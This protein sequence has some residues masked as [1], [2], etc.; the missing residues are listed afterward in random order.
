MIVQLLISAALAGGALPGSAAP[1]RDGLI[2]EATDLLLSGEALPPDMELRLMALPPAERIEVLIFM[3][4]SGMLTTPG[5]TI[6]R[7][8]APSTRQE[9]SDERD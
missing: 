4:R 8:L 7:L 9:A 2:Q 3:R 1:T 6:D 5:W